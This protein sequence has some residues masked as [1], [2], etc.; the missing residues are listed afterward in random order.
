MKWSG[1]SSVTA[2]LFI[3]HV[4]LIWPVL[5]PHLADIGAF[6]EAVSIAMGGKLGV[7]ALPALNDYPLARLLSA[8]AHIPVGASEFWFVHAGS[9]GRVVL[10][11]LLW[12]SSYT[13]AKRFSDLS[14]PL[15]LCGFI[16][17]SP[18]TAILVTNSSHALFSAMSAFALGQIISFHRGRQFT[19]LRMA[20]VFVGLAMLSRMGEGA[21]VAGSFVGLSLLLGVLD[22]RVVGT[23]AAAVIPLTVIVGGYMLTYY[24]VTGRTPFGA[25]TYFYMTFEQGHGQAYADQF[26]GLNSYAEG[27]VE[28]RRIFGTPE[29]N[30]HSVL[31][32]IQRNPG[33][34]VA[35]IPRL[36]RLAF[37]DAIAAYGGPL[38]LCLA[39]LALQGAIELIRRRQLMLLC[40]LLFWP[41]YLVIY[42]LLVFQRSHLLLPF[43][44]VFC[45]ASIGLTAFVS[46][47]GKR[48]HLW[49]GAF[50]GVVAGV[51]AIDATL[52][53]MQGLLVF[54]AGLWIVWTA[55]RR[56]GKHEVAIHVAVVFLIGMMSLSREG[57]SSPR[58]RR[59][60]VAPEE[61]AML[62]LRRHVEQGAVVAAYAPR[63]PW[64]ARLKW[65]S[66]VNRREALRSDEDLERWIRDNDVRAIYL[67]DS[68]RRHESAV[69]RV[70]D[71]QIGKDTEIA[72]S[73]DEPYIRILRVKRAL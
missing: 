32:A 60:G 62:F 22:R 16:L 35:R 3:S 14:H 23:L 54:L 37:W 41:A 46:L 7:E 29:Q 38:S 6:D 39:L 20:S 2:L 9:I 13:V 43:Y 17:I 44:L 28:S 42:V 70:I 47:S 31:A 65:V 24:G 26:P 68:F 53:F 66:L 33:A 61:R 1:W 34:Y 36:A 11:A 15:I 51:A 50:V 21:I 58:L 63:E 48:R 55:L 25:D 49:T 5:T 72:F 27:E 69:W 52:P 12:I 10:L 57:M 64:A 45:L 71:G 4:V 59:L 30:Q 73:S 56:Y 8:L 40:M 18:V 19:H 67:D